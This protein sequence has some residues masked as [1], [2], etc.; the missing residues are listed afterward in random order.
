VPSILQ[1][2]AEF[3]APAVIGTGEPTEV[4]LAACP[5]HWV[6]LFFYPRD[7][8]V[9]CP[10]EILELSKRVRE[11]RDLDAEVIAISVDTVERHRQW[12]AEKLGRVEIPLA[13][14]PSR[15]IA[16]AYGV[17]L[18]EQGVA[19]R[20]T[21]VVDPAGVV[22]YAAFHDLAVGRSVSEILRVLE[23]LQA[24]APVPAEWRPGD[25]TLEK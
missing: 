7:F 2:A 19:A 21:F 1:R 13:A 11:L 3:K 4:S 10:T 18:E 20:A 16:R 6:V 22:R 14:D 23:A 8:T 24:G 25:P 15:G 9:V 12:I 17:L 5:G